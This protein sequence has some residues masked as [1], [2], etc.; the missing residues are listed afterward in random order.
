M[1]YQWYLCCAAGYTPKHIMILH[2]CSDD[3][4]ITYKNLTVPQCC[5]GFCVDLLERFSI[6]LGFTYELFRVEDGKWGVLQVS[7]FPYLHV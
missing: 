6:D 7:E 1:W 4:A 2:C 3:G 5:S